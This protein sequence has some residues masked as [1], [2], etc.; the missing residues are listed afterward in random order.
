[1]MSEWLVFACSYP[2]TP[3]DYGLQLAFN[4]NA[5]EGEKHGAAC[6]FDIENNF[7]IQGAIT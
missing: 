5:R 3:R 1:M 6:I 2:A 4:P 7:V